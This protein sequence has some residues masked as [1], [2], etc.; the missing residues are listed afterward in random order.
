MWDYENALDGDP[1][2]VVNDYYGG[3]GSPAEVF[4]ARN[5]IVN[6]VQYIY[7]GNT[8]RELVIYDFTNSAEVARI[9]NPIP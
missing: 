3:S 9:T 7:Y 5:S 8:N 2:I 6:S 1:G 4:L